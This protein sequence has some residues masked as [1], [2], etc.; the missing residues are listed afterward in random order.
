VLLD[1]TGHALAIEDLRG[2]PT[3]LLF[4][5]GAWCPA[6]RAQLTGF[7][8]V[9][10]PYLAAGVRVLAISPD[11]PSD[12]AAFQRRLNVPFPLLSDE[13]EHWASEL[14][15]ARG[16]CQLL[17]DAAGVV[18]WGAFGENWRVLEPPERVLQAAYRLGGA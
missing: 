15:G 5:L 6:C 10:E 13:K 1:A 3:V 8:D 2:R 12:L 9:A 17:I 16:H 11:P 18:R 4:Y 14:C 7:A